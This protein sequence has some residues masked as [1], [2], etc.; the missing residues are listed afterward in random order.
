MSGYSPQVRDQAQR[1]Q[2]M[3]QNINLLLQQ[4]RTMESDLRETENAI[5]ELTKAPEDALVY[6]SVGGIMLKKNRDDV[7][8]D[9]KEKQETLDIRLKSMEKQETRMKQQ[10]EEASENLK[11]MIEGGA[12]GQVPDFMKDNRTMKL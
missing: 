12:G 2:Q 7:L 6:K 1:M 5:E 11:S 4:K 9:L 10:L 8:S 3:E